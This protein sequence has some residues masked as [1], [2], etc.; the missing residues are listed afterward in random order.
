[1]KEDGNI[2][3]KCNDSY[4]IIANPFTIEDLKAIL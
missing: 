4:Y 2:Y 3:L 1:M